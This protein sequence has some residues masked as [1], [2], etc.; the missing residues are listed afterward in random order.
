MALKNKKIAFIGAGN[1]G[2]AMIR[3]LLKAG[4]SAPSDIIAADLRAEHLAGLKASLHV[5]T[6][7]DAVE[8]A[9]M[10]QIVVLAVKPQSFSDLLP[11]LRVNGS[12]L[13]I[14]IAAGLRLDKLKA[15]LGNVPLIRVM[16]NTPGLLGQGASAYCLGGTAG[17]AH[18]EDA[19]ALLGCLGIVLRV[20]ESQMDAVTALSG[21]GPAYLFLFMEAMQAAGEKLGLDAETSFKLA[22]QTIKGAAAMIEK[23]DDTPARLREK[24]TSPGGTTAAALKAFEDAG[25]RDIVLKAMTAARDRGIELGKE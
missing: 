24:V 1:M 21:S 20:S 18:A 3:G 25:F 19:E 17:A 2:E 7:V 12:Q 22:A 8:A 14:S 10:A 23:R 5:T 13:V 6:T 15:Q 11:K 9:A 4:L 16:P